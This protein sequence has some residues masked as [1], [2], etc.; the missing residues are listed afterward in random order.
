MRSYQ[1]AFALATSMAAGAAAA[2]IAADAQ[3]AA[4]NAGQAPI[5]SCPQTASAPAPSEAGLTAGLGA[6]G[7]VA[8]TGQAAAGMKAPLT[9]RFHFGDDA[10]DVTRTVGQVQH[11]YSFN[12]RFYP[13][14]TV[15]DAI[16]TTVTSPACWLSVTSVKD[17]VHRYAGGDR[18]LTSSAV[19]QKLWADAAGDTATTSR[20]PAKAVVLASGQGFA[21]ALAGVPLAA[22]KQGPLLLTEPTGLTKATED[23][24]KRVLPAGATVYVL[25]GQAA[26]SSH[27][28]A[29]LRA[30]GYQVTRYAGA[31]R[32]GTAMRIATSGLDNPAS[33][34]VVTGNDFADALAAGPA[35]TGD[36]LTSQGKPAAIVLSNGGAITDPATRS[37]IEARVGSVPDPVYSHVLTLGGQATCAVQSIDAK[38][39][40][41]PCFLA[42]LPRGIGGYDTIGGSKAFR[43]IVGEDRFQTAAYVATSGLTSHIEWSPDQTWSFHDDD[44]LFGL[45]SGTTYADALTGGAALAVEHAPVLLTARTYFPAAVGSSIATATTR[46]APSTFEA[47]IFGGPVAIA[48]A[49]ESALDAK[50]RP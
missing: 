41:P 28:D 14:V 3:A 9:Y 17:S 34:V 16:G 38:P 49:L 13:T 5:Y 31:D 30:D 19:S 50:I 37:F 7:G 27:V 10:T 45:A 15:T 32:Y 1:R 24:I 4:P 46:P 29:Q 48:P 36:I 12:A 43:G 18:Y 22:Y 44:G 42:G 2:G 33:A 40:T 26:L 6:D 25:G 35:A 39:G 23:E 20:R 8:L 47:D 21:D 11:A